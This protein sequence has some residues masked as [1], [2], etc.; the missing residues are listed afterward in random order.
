MLLE[1]LIFA[2]FPLHQNKIKVNVRSMV[3]NIG[4]SNCSEA[5]TVFAGKIILA[6]WSRSK[7]SRVSRCKACR[8]LPPQNF[9]KNPNFF[10]PWYPKLSNC[11]SSLCLSS[12]SSKTLKIFF[13]LTKQLFFHMKNAS[14]ALL[15]KYSK[16]SSKVS[17]HPEG[18][19]SRQIDRAVDFFQ[20]IK[21]IIFIQ[22]YQ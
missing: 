5:K 6:K 7:Q 9:F 14:S 3:I 15:Q 4:V 21:I 10:H 19:T 11:P 13:P 16:I 18:L 17:S 20:V 1:R 12:I 22:D 2:C 8:L